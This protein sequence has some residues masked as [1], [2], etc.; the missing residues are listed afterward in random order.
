MFMT[1]A[2]ADNSCS[3]AGTFG[4]GLVKLTMPITSGASVRRL[5]SVSTFGRRRAGIFPGKDLRDHLA[6]ALAGIALEN[7]EAPGRELAMVGHARTDGEDG[8]E[9]GRG[10]AGPGHLARLDRAAGFQ[11]FDGVGHCD[12]LFG[13]SSGVPCRDKHARPQ[14]KASLDRFQDQAASRA[15]LTSGGVAS[16][17]SAAIASA[18][19][20]TFWP[21]LP[22]RRTETDCVSASFLPTT[23]S[24][25]IFAS[26]CSRTL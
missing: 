13:W 4:C 20:I 1:L 21:S 15:R 5:R 23:S 25:G 9:L 8:L 26:E 3:N 12:V 10:G 14:P 11:E 24:A 6:G 17:T 18:V 19:G 2:P 16:S 22:R 7:D